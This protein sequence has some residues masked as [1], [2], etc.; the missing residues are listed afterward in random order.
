[1]EDKLRRR[2]SPQQIAGWLKI[3]NPKTVAHQ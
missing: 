2:W 1:V 3:T